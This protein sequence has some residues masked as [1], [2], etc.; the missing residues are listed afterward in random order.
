MHALT[1]PSEL[2]SDLPSSPSLP[3]LCLRA[4]VSVEYETTRPVS[5]WGKRLLSCRRSNHSDSES[6]ARFLLSCLLFQSSPVSSSIFV[7]VSRANVCSRADDCDRSVGDLLTVYPPTL[8]IY[9]ARG[10]IVFAHSQS[11][12]IL[13][14][15]VQNLEDHLR[16]PSTSSHT[17]ISMSF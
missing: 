1:S 11:F 10:H 8:P 2:T 9:L 3:S 6:P 14:T 17:T 7:G 5:Y 13:R 15:T 12:D 4:F 16:L